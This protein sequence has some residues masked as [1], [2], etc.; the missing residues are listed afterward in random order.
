MS[1]RTHSNAKSFKRTSFVVFRKDVF[2]YLRAL[3]ERL[4]VAVVT[5]RVANI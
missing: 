2:N 1:R 5:G 3:N 4:F